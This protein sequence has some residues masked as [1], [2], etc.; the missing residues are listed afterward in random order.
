ML[1]SQFSAIFCDFLRFST[2]FSDKIA[3]FIKNQRCD[4]IFAQFGFVLSQKRQFFRRIFLRNYFKN[5][6]IGPGMD[7]DNTIF[8]KKLPL[9]TMTGS[10]VTRL[11]EF[12]PIG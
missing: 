11:G 12:S 3:L 10:K 5:H 2:I 1:L 7:C 6:N 8:K 4:P 9:Y